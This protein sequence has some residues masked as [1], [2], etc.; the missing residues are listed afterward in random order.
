[1]GKLTGWMKNNV[2]VFSEMLKTYSMATVFCLA[3]RYPGYLVEIQTGPVEANPFL[4]HVER[5]GAG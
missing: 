3:R 5:I 1:M 4:L 2:D